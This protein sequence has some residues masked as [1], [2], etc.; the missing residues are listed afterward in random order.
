M[1]LA[2]QSRRHVAGFSQE[3]WLSVALAPPFLLV[4][5]EEE[6]VGADWASGSSEHGVI[7]A[8]LFQKPF[9]SES[10]KDELGLE[11][12]LP[13]GHPGHPGLCAMRPRDVPLPLGLAVFVCPVWMLALPLG[14]K[15]LVYTA[16]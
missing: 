14:C 9:D 3:P 1:L 11:S 15:I 4:G 16:L 5:C 8:S 7:I 12:S 2:Q 6:V 10:A 13:S